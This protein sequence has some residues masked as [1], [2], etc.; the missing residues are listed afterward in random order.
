MELEWI[1]KILRLIRSYKIP[2]AI[3]SEKCRKWNI[4]TPITQENST[5]V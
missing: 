1:R 5:F 4:Y 3:L 2:S